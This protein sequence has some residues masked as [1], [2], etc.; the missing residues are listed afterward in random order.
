MRHRKASWYVF[1][2]R[3][4]S[5]SPATKLERKWKKEGIGMSTNRI[6][7]LVAMAVAAVGTIPACT[8]VSVAPAG[9]SAQLHFEVAGQAPSTKTSISGEEKPGEPWKYVYTP[10]W[11]ADDH[12]AVLFSANAD[13]TPREE[14][15]NTLAA[16]E[17]AL[18]AGDISAPATGSASVIYPCSAWVGGK[19]GYAAV[20]AAQEPALTSFDPSCDILC[21]EPET[22]TAV[23]GTVSLSGLLF[24]RLTGVLRIELTGPYAA[25]NHIRSLTLTAPEGTKLAGNVSVDLAKADISNVP[26]GTNVVTAAYEEGPVIGSGSVFLSLL[27]CVIPKNGQVTVEVRTERFDIVKTITLKENMTIP[28]GGVAVLRM[29]VTDEHCTSLLDRTGWTTT[30]VASGLKWHNFEGTDPVTGL[31]QKVN[32]VEADL[33]NPGLRFSFVYSDS[34]KKVSEMAA[35]KNALAVTNATYGAGQAGI[36]HIKTDG[37][38]RRTIDFGEEGYTAWKHKAAVWYDGNAT[39]GFYNYHAKAREISKSAYEDDTHQNLFSSAPLLIDS[40]AHTDLSGFNVGTNVAQVHPRTVLAV[41]RGGRLLLVTIDGR[42]STAKGMTCAQMQDFLDRFFNP[43]YAINMDGGG[44]TAMFVAGNGIVNY[45]CDG[46]AENAEDVSRD[47]TAERNLPTFFVLTSA[48]HIDSISETAD[49]S[50]WY[51]IR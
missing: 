32:V 47:H 17:K 4:P 46:T 14:L 51:Q 37:V 45:P 28:Q 30:Q 16:G 7:W 24:H 27:P 19:S 50:E 12:V 13:D 36:V 9:E 29:S 43:A 8:K 39:L 6:K 5:V 2:P 40:G 33:T 31:P 21:A 25:G 18:F 49:D 41:T 15:A 22:Y 34:D 44:S 26:S 1:R 48:S 23:G 10:Q 3:V 20:K 11:G 42:L 38:V 35:E